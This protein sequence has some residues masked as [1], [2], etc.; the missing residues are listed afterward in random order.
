MDF[1]FELSTRKNS[2]RTFLFAAESYEDRLTWMSK[3][4]EVI[5]I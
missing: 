2:G 4:A 3:L 5:I 1:A